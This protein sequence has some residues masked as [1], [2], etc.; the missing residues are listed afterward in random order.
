M[1]NFFKFVGR[2]M[3]DLRDRDEKIKAMAELLLSKA[4]MLQYHCGECGS[5]LFEK[6]GK[7]ICP[8]CGEQKKPV[9]E[10]SEGRTR[11]EEERQSEA[12]SKKLQAF[13]GRRVVVK[14]ESTAYRGMCEKVDDESL[15]I[16][17]RNA[18]GLKPFTKPTEAE[19]GQ[20]S[21]LLFVHGSVIE[22]VWLEKKKD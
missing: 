6:E 17:L 19:W 22:A 21:E 1:I 3:E 9:K 15:S 8:V 13:L 5:P 2:E 10:T 20:L 11:R 7:I 16:T 4:T 14:T 18:E 12:R